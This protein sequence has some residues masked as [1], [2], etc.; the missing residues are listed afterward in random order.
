MWDTF[1]FRRFFWD[2]PVKIKQSSLSFILSLFLVSFAVVSLANKSLASDVATFEKE[3]ADL[4]R[5]IAARKKS[6]DSE[7]AAALQ[8]LDNL[9]KER[10]A[11]ERK[12]DRHELR[13]QRTEERLTFVDSSIKELGAWY[14]GLSAIDKGLN[15]SSYEAKMSAHKADQN[16]VRVELRDLE[17][18]K[19]QI[20]TDIENNK[21]QSAALKA[22]VNTAKDATLADLVKKKEEKSVALGKLKTQQQS[23]SVQQKAP[24]QKPA[25]PVFKAYVYAISGKSSGEVERSLRLRKW[26]ESYQAKYI[27]ANWNDINAS[28][29]P[30]SGS[31]LK[32]LSQI[33]VELS[34]IPE[35]SNVILIG[36]GIGGGAAILA[37]TEV[38]NK[39]N[40]RIDFLITIDPMGMG[41]S[42][43][44]AVYKTEA[45]CLGR[46]SPEQYL[47]CLSKGQKREIT[48]N[49]KN[50]YNR[51][52]REA[53][54]PIDAKDRMT[55]GNREYALSTGR[56][57]IAS[58]ATTDNQKRMYYGIDKKAH[59][60]ILTDA[61]AELPK[62]L[63]E[64]LR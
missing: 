15:N 54:M 2:L 11:N 1:K 26:V 37:A 20:L 41:D 55:V 7:S 52:Q 24:P 25:E 47:D 13:I 17:N 23:Q 19:K 45:F 59:E 12:L 8:E 5:A 3:L 22:K 56:F 34:N 49:V 64:H 28:D 43:M 27:E 44:N 10:V 40:R 33:E 60:L 6:L 63:V 30:A 4:D 21:T 35:S 32:F 36:Y 9:E 39:L 16:A 29:N 14:S 57:L 50:F 18:E 58:P 62:L 42:R 31:M 61:A 51:W 46:I 48:A 53:T 38:A